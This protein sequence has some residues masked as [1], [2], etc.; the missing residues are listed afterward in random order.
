MPTRLLSISISLYLSLPYHGQYMNKLSQHKKKKFHLRCSF[1]C[2]SFTVQVIRGMERAAC[3][4]FPL[5]CIS[6]GK[7]IGQFHEAVTDWVC[8]WRV[9]EL[10]AMGIPHIDDTD[11]AD[12]VSPQR[13]TDNMF[14]DL[15]AL[16][17]LRIECCL[18]TLKN[19]TARVEVQHAYELLNS[20]RPDTL[21]F[22]DRVKFK[23][24]ADPGPRTHA[25]TLHGAYAAN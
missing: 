23:S 24:L 10:A 14:L 11:S 18:R 17:N 22:A 5:R 1:F 16:L 9:R 3:S 20:W 15:S 8:Q 4:S 7:N 2:N 25:V 19:W 12:I 6:C 21:D 13:C